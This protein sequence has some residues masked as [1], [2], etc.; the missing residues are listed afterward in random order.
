MQVR[1]NILNGEDELARDEILKPAQY[2]PRMIETSAFSY[3]LVRI[4][5]ILLRPQR[6]CQTKTYAER[7]AAIPNGRAAK[8]RDRNAVAVSSSVFGVY[9][10]L[11]ARKRAT[12]Y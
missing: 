4:R 3:L 9:F 8:N 7:V 6:P 11:V 5:G 10:L 12:I 2:I 1:C